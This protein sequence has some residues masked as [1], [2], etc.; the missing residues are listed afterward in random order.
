MNMFDEARSIRGMLTLRGMKQSELAEMLGVSQPY[1]ANKLRLLNFSDKMQ[2]KILES[3]LSER[4]A[5]T[6][7]RLPEGKAEEA[8][9]IMARGQ[10]TTM[11]SELLVERIL[12]EIMP[13]PKAPE[14]ESPRERI[15]GLYD[16]IESSLR[17][18]RLYGINARAKRENF[19]GRVYISICIG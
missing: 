7:L 12:E 2:N 14:Y 16:M 11:E 5:R 17:D 15:I 9:E 4:H 6:L 3:G 13:K 8:L 10:M 18:F 19:G 1:I